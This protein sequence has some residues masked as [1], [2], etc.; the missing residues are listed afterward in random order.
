M[1]FTKYRRAKIATRRWG[2]LTNIG[3]TKKSNEYDSASESLSMRM[4]AMG[5][6]GGRQ[7]DIRLQR[8][9]NQTEKGRFED[10]DLRIEE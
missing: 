10:R 6:A 3:R 2:D 9:G 7:S 8:S 4:R 5:Y 1:K